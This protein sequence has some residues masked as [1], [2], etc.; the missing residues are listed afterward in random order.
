MLTETTRDLDPIPVPLCA[1]LD[2]D[3]IR[4][5]PATDESV[6]WK[7]VDWRFGD[8]AFVAY[9]VPGSDE[10]HRFDFTEPVPW[11]TVQAPDPGVSR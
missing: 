3:V 8:G 4:C 10:K 9:T 2:D 6:V 11:V 5:H 1:L 7:V